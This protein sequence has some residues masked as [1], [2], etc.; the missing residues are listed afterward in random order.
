MRHLTCKLIDNDTCN[1]NI[2]LSTI[3]FKGLYPS[4][5]LKQALI[6]ECITPIDIG[7]CDI[8]SKEFAQGI[9]LLNSHI[10]ISFAF[11]V[12]KPQYVRI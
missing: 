9:L 2:M 10:S 8:H 11:R 5:G 1:L 4:E 12:K 7:G 3:N 6:Y